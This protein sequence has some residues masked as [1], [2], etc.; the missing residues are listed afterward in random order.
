MI[1]NK[2]DNENGKLKKKNVSPQG[3]FGSS[4]PF[5]SP[6]CPFQRKLPGVGEELRRAR[7]VRKI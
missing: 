5:V 1:I 3:A 7:R 6:K 4:V 2:R